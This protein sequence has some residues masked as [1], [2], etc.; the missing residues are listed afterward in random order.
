M[1]PLFGPLPKSATTVCV[2]VSLFVHFTVPPFG[3]VICDGV[4]IISLMLMVPATALWLVVVVELVL[5]LFAGGVVVLLF[6]LCVKAMTPP[7][8]IMTII[9]TAANFPIRNSRIYVYYIILPK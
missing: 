9:M 3:T 6:D 5:E 2:V 4:N 1:S 8:M 7:I